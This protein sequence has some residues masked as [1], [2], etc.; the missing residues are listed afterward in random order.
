MVRKQKVI[1]AGAKGNAARAVF[2]HASPFPMI[3]FKFKTKDDE[4][5][6]MMQ[7]EDASRFTQTA[8]NAIEAATPSIPR[9]KYNI[10]WT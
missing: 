7:L 9:P 1:M 2:D 4:V 8:I 5:T 3:E 10:P 6:I